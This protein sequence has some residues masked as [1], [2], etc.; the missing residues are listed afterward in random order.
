MKRYIFSI[1]IFI[2]ITTLLVGGIWFLTKP[3]KLSPELAFLEEQGF[4]DE[5]GNPLMSPGLTQQDINASDESFQVLATKLNKDTGSYQLAFKLENKSDQNKE[6]YL[7]PVSEKDQLEFK[8]IK[9]VI[10]NKNI[11]AINKEDVS[12]QPLETLYDIKQHKKE[13]N[14]E[15]AQAYN[16]IDANNYKGDPIKITL[17]PNSSLVA[18]SQWEIKD[19]GRGPSSTLRAVY[20]LVYGSAGGAKEELTILT[21]HS[22]PKI[23][24]AHV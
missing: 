16:D 1:L 17:G 4:L 20:F 9:G 23:G 10:N 6:F 7:I 15:L 5:E 2:F 19:K 8:E 18:K 21:V 3:D 22:H 24:R 14:P 13:L 12:N 11:L